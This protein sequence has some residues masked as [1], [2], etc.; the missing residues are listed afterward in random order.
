MHGSRH[1]GNSPRQK[2]TSAQVTR[3][4]S[5]P[6]LDPCAIHHQPFFSLECAFLVPWWYLYCPC[7]SSEASP[8]TSRTLDTYL[9]SSFQRL[10]RHRPKVHHQHI[11]LFHWS[12][13]LRRAGAS[14]SSGCTVLR[15]SPSS[16]L[17][18][19]AF[20]VDP[21]TYACSASFLQLDND[22][23]A[24]IPVSHRHQAVVCFVSQLSSPRRE[25]PRPRGHSRYEAAL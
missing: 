1:S 5:C 25:L 13:A 8:R 21:H 15:L 14:A 18:A 17:D 6:N 12:F 10:H 2:P 9:D 16:R 20:V 4:P 19:D 11:Q 24:H 7:P 22:V 3:S 23:E